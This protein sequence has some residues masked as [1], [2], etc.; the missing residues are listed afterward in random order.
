MFSPTLI[1]PH[2]VIMWLIDTGTLRLVYVLSPGKHP[3]AILSH[4]W[5]EDEITFQDMT[6]PGSE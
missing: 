3:Y 6:D 4:T 2:A 1:D 5:E